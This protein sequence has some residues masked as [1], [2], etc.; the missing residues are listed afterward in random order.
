MKGFLKKIIVFLLPLLLLSFLTDRLFNQV[1]RSVL[2]AQGEYPVWNDLYDGKANSEILIYGS[3]RALGHIDPL[4][5]S[6][7]LELS[8]YNLGIDGHNFWLQHLR[9]ELIMQKAEPPKL[10]LHSLDM[11]TLEKKNDLYNPDQFLPYL[12]QNREMW[13]AIHAYNGYHYTDYVC[14]LVRYYGKTEAIL[15]ALKCIANGPEKQAQHRVRGFLSEELTWNDDLSEARKKMKG[16]RV[17]LHQES[18]QL[19]E[20]FLEVCAQEHIA[21]VLVYSPE[22]Y[23]GRDFVSNR[24]S[25]M[26][27]YRSIALKHRLPLL[28][29]SQDS[30]CLEKKWFYNSSHL[31]RNGSRAFTQKLIADLKKTQIKFIFKP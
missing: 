14:P 23:E 1:K 22:Y 13:D 4:M 18:L 20:H 29:Y 7:S 11:F 26:Q 5:I 31:N 27:L 6:D 2:H 16:Y 19:Y 17:K 24:D 12:W 3:S 10:I 8:S 28:N 25:V 15:K 9:H 21:V 30:M